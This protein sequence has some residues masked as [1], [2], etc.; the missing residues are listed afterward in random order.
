[1][2]NNKRNDIVHKFFSGW[3]SIDRSMTKILIAN[4]YN[5]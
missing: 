3:G 1:M 4:I 5:I 2:L